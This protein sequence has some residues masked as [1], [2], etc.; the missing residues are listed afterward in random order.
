MQRLAAAGLIALVAAYGAHAQTAQ[1][2]GLA[3]FAEMMDHG[4]FDRLLNDIMD[5]LADAI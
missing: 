1:E 2:R 4:G 3:I 5:D